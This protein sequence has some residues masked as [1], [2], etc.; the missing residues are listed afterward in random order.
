[1]IKIFIVDS[2]IFCDDGLF[3]FYLNRV[4]E[5]RRKKVNSL[6]DRKRQNQSLAAGAILPAAMQ[7]SG[8]SA[9]IALTYN[10]FGKPRLVSPENMFFNLSHSE[11]KV[12]CAL[13]DREVGCDIQRVNGANYLKIKRRFTLREQAMIDGAGENARDIF[14]RLWT[15]KESYLKALGVGFSR[16]LNSFEVEFSNGHAN[17]VDPEEEGVWNIWEYQSVKDYKIACCTQCDCTDLSPVVLDAEVIKTY[18]RSL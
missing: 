8:I 17:I 16:P 14:F 3:S 12:V 5:D 6:A 10:G 18:N 7:Y 2:G 13:S 11:G 4:D 9:D 15:V 1:M